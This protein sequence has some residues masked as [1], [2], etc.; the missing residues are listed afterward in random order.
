MMDAQDV[1]QWLN[2]NLPNLAMIPEIKVKP[3][4]CI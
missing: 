3:G 2:P 4:V 1:H